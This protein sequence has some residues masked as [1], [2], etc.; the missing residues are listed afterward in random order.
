MEVAAKLKPTDWRT[1]AILAIT[2]ALITIGVLNLRARLDH[3]LVPYDGVLWVDTEQGIVAQSVEPG[4]PADRTGVRR[5]D[6]LSGISLDGGRQFDQVTEAAKVQIYLE[7]AKVG[8]P[9]SYLIERRNLAGQVSRWAADI[10]EL[11]PEPQKLWQ[12][13]Y[14]AIIGWVYLIIGLYVLIRQRRAR[15]TLHFY[16]IC[17]TAFVVYFYSYT[18]QLDRLD[19]IVF[20]ADNIALI[21]LAPLFLHFCAVFPEKRKILG[22]HPWL[23]LALYA[24]AILMLILEASLPRLAPSLGQQ[25]KI[26]RVQLDFFEEKIQFPL[27]FLGGGALLLHTFLKAQNPVLK[28]QMKWVVWGLVGIVPFTG[29][30]IY[31]QV[32]Q[33]PSPL[34]EAM[35]IVPLIFIPLSFGYSIVRY[36]LMDVDV[37]MRRS[38]VHL[39]TTAVVAGLF[40]LLL[41]AARDFVTGVAPAWVT[42]MIVAGALV[43]AMLFAPLKNYLQ[44]RIDR[45]FYGER[46]NARTGVREFARMLSTMTTLEPLLSSVSGRLRR[47]LSVD[48]IAVFIRD[49]TEPSRFRMA[50]L[51][52]IPADSRLSTD[53]VEFL[54]QQ[55]DGHRIVSLD[56]NQAS[57][58]AG[59]DLGGL[60][61]FVPCVARDRI[62]AVLGLGRT[63][64]GDLLTSEDIELLWAIAP[65]VAI[66]V[67]NSLLYQEQ[68]K[69][70]GE[71]AHLKEFSESI[72]ES[73]NVG[74]L[75][76]DPRGIITTWN[77][78]LE[79]LLGMDRKDALGRKVYQVLDPELVR[80]LRDVIGE[81]RWAVQ[82]SRSIYKFRITTSDGR[83]LCLNI[84]ITPFETK[85]GE[86]VGSLIVVEDVSHRLRLEQQLQQSEK[87]SSIGLLAAGVAHE[88]NT[89]LT[90]ISS[91]AQMLLKQLPKTDPRYNLLVKI[92]EQAQRA[93]NIVTSLLNFSRVETTEFTELDV[94]RILED[95]LRL[96][97]P[98]LRGRRVRLVKHYNDDVSNVMGN[99]TKL[100]QVFMNLVLNARD[101]MPD[102]GLLTIRTYSTD[103]MVG[104]DVVDTGIG[105]PPENIRQIY[106]P[107]FTTKGIGRGTGLGLALSYGIIH[108]HGG[109]IHVESQVGKGTQFSIYLPCKQIPVSHRQA[110][111]RLAS[112]D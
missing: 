73:I 111:L 82:D 43:L 64:G 109:R 102:G 89:P 17:L 30:L 8:N 24:P 62:I 35:A 61:Y 28:Q 88:V 76:V 50:H 72:I 103:S 7:E 26:A 99:A 4:S 91:Y 92:E 96:I 1:I 52:G 71:L 108:E 53:F 59:A 47:M 49:E 25:I 5:G 11:T 10:T 93:S 23:V 104:I 22:R 63:M 107:F 15:H 69:R 29:F 101:A 51:E 85:G 80:A 36:R 37:I 74:I 40:I 100:Q 97:E 3:P 67:E 87:L 31:K 65:Y 12:H 56:E 86:R 90:G 54:Q 20:F 57:L 13:I 18:R 33:S 38:L 34:L 112:G 45:L 58:I 81:A 60:C 6:L 27:C 19:W 83:E 16:S 110:E 39:I 70:A 14:M 106:D 46:Y 75:A 55:P 98:Q 9:I 32:V 66:A 44:V 95:T 48:K 42:T 78:A 84:S 105:I 79:E 2:G 94:H 77:S 21:F 68:A 41:V